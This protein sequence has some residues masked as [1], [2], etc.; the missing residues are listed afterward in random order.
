MEAVWIIG[1]VII[2]LGILLWRHRQAKAKREPEAPPERRVSLGSLLNRTDV[3]VL[4]TETTGFGPKAEVVEI[5]IIDTTGAVRYDE[6]VMPQGSV[7]TGASNVHGLTKVL[8]RK[9]GA[10][11]WPEHHAK[12]VRLLSQASVICAYNTDYDDRLLEQTT[13]RY[14]L[15]WPKWDYWCCMMLAYAEERGIAHPKRSGEY[16]WH[17]LADAMK[18]EGLSFTGKAHRARSDAMATLDIMRRLASKP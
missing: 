3:L 16:R 7:S 18:Y 1:A 9:E 15:S 8:L 6:L 10:R 4:D 2:G 5:T 13:A 14:G 17:K 11:P 12:V